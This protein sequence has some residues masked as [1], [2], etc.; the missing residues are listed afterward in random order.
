MLSWYDDM[1]L[2]SAGVPNAI[3]RHLRQICVRSRREKA[4]KRWEEGVGWQELHEDFGYDF[5][6]QCQDGVLIGIEP[7]LR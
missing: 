3:S 1:A 5:V 6:G 7:L 2:Q 4:D